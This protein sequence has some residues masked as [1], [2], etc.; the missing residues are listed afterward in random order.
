MNTESLYATQARL[1]Q[2]TGIG[3]G[4]ATGEIVDLALSGAAASGEVLTWETRLDPFRTAKDERSPIHTAYR[5]RTSHEVDTS[6]AL[7]LI[8]KHCFDRGEGNWDIRRIKMPS[9][10]FT[11]QFQME[12]GDVIE[13]RGAHIEE[14]QISLTE[15]RTATMEISWHAMSRV[16][17]GTIQD[18]TQTWTRTLL[19]STNESAATF[20]TETITDRATDAMAIYS[21]EF[22]MRRDLQTV[23]FGPDGQASAVSNAPWKILAELSMPASAATEAARPSQGGQAGAFGLWIG[24]PGEELILTAGRVKAFLQNEPLKSSELRDHQLLIEFQPS[25]LGRLLD[26]A[27]TI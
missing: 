13:F 14:L 9:P 18:A 22:I 21:A 19:V 24:P 6:L 1:F 3:N 5:M 17:G 16:T 27:G 4:T 25:A 2:E 12:G 26:V 11:V 15:S 23:Q 10:S 20:T 7:W 8:S